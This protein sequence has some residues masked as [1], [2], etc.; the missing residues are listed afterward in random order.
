MG[1]KGGSGTPKG[2]GKEKEKAAEAPPIAP[3]SSSAPIT[4]RRFKIRMEDGSSYMIPCDPNFSIGKFKLEILR[5]YPAL[6]ADFRLCLEKSY[7]YDDDT[8]ASLTLGDSDVLDV[9]V[10]P[11]PPLPIPSSSY[12]PVTDIPLKKTSLSPSYAS[13][14][15]S[16]SSSLLTPSIVPASASSSTPF[17]NQLHFNNMPCCTFPYTRYYRSNS[18]PPNIMVTLHIKGGHSSKDSTEPRHQGRRQN[19]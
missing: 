18:R 7:L 5:R 3:A 19:F 8:L 17:D 12:V 11:T 4:T 9:R 13:S 6:A 14:S 10:S 15:S 2:K 16:S 1:K